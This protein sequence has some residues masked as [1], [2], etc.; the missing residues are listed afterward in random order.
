MLANVPNGIRQFTHITQF[1]EQLMALGT[2]FPLLDQFLIV[3]PPVEQPPVLHLL[4][5]RQMPMGDDI[6]P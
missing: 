3:L 5:V 2:Y 6:C 1:D 4:L